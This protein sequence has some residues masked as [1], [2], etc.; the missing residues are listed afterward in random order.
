M[1]LKKLFFCCFKANIAGVDD[2]LMLDIDGFIAETNATNVFLVKNGRV[3][4]PYADA[5]LPG[6]TRG[7]VKQLYQIGIKLIFF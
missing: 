4:T 1:L 3:L 5:C 7:L 6:I 2:A